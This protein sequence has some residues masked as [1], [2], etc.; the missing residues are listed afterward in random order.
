MLGGNLSDG[1]NELVFSIYLAVTAA[2]I[3]DG[4]MITMGPGHHRSLADHPVS[5]TVAS[6][7][8]SYEQAFGITLPDLEVAGITEYLLGLATLGIRC[9][10]SIMWI[11]TSF[12]TS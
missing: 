7:A 8:A 5:E 12:S 1:N 9:N 10:R 6:I 4:K 11:M 2:R 3:A